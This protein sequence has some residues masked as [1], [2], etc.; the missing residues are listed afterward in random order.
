MSSMLSTGFFTLSFRWCSS[1]TVTVLNETVST[2]SFIFLVQETV[3]KDKRKTVIE[4]KKIRIIIRSLVKTIIIPLTILTC[5]N[6][7]LFPN[8]LGRNDASMDNT[9]SANAQKPM[10]RKNC[11]KKIENSIF[12]YP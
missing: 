5:T 12:I 2:F 3:Q 10:L 7:H 4:M 9:I 1:L 6:I 8:I 11:N